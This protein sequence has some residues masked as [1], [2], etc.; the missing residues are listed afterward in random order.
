[1]PEL[2][3]L[4]ANPGDVVVPLADV[5]ELLQSALNSSELQELTTELIARRTTFVQAGDVITAELMN[6]VLADIGNLQARVAELENGIPSQEAPRIF[7]VDPN[8]GV[9]IGETLTVIGENLAPSNLT[10]VRIGNRTVSAFSGSSQG[11]SLTQ[12]LRG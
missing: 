12:V 8:T 7:F 9:R 6:Q 5:L 10:S 2:N 4:N 3:L 1:M 11:K